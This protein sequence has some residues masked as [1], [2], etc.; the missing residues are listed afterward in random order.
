VL[1]PELFHLVGSAFG[2]LQAQHVG[3]LGG[4]KLKKV[5]LQHGAQAVHVPRDQFHGDEIM[6][7]RLARKA[8]VQQSRGQ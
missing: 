8:T 4:E 2:L 6:V 5:F 3:L 1:R 7:K